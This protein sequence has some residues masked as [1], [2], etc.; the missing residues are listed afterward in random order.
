MRRR[1]LSI[2]FNTMWRYISPWSSVIQLQCKE[3]S[4]AYFCVNTFTRTKGNTRIHRHFF[5]QS[6][7]SITVTAIYMSHP[8]S[9]GAQPGEWNL[10]ILSSNCTSCVNSDEGKRERTT[11]GGAE[12]RHKKDSA[13]RWSLSFTLTLFFLQLNCQISL[14]YRDAIFTHHQL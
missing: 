14:S 7:N 2:L 3:R 12:K 10:W 8:T 13:S 4:Y 5:S 9:Q 6:L 11:H 1:S